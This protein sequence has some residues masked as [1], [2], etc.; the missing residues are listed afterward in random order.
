MTRGQHIDFGHLKYP[1]L[2]W[3]FFS[4][5]ALKI[6]DCVKFSQNNCNVLGILQVKVLGS[7]GSTSGRKGYGRQKFVTDIDQ[8][9]VHVS[10]NS[11]KGEFKCKLCGKITSSKRNSFAHLE[12]KHFTVLHTSQDTMS[13]TVTAATRSLTPAPNWQTTSTVTVSRK[14]K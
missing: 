13:T 3:C 6:P 10:G 7:Q 12:N 14:N 1:R 8:H 4:L 2:L 9:M 11:R 5:W